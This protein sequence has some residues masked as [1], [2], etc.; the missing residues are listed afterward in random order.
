MRTFTLLL[1]LLAAPAALAQSPGTVEGR[2]DT[3]RMGTTLTVTVQLRATPGN[4]GLGTSTIQFTYND[5]ALDYVSGAYNNY[6]GN[7]ASYDGGFAGYNSTITR[8][9][10]NEVSINIM[11]GFSSFGNGQALPSTYTD[12][13]TF[14]FTITDASATQDLAW[15]TLELRNGPQTRY[16]NGT[17][18]TSDDALPVELT[19]F[20]A[21]QSADGTARL[22]WTTASE[23]DNSGFAIEH[24]AY[25]SAEWANVGWAAGAGTTLEGQSYAFAVSG[26]DP[27]THRFRLIQTDLDGATEQ[28]GVVELAVEMTTGAYRFTSPR[29]NPSAGM[30]RM[31]VAVRQAQRVDVV[32]YDLL[33]R[34][35]AV[36]FSGELDA[37]RQQT[38]AFDAARLSAGM[39]V[40]RLEG[41][42]FAATQVL[43]VAR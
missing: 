28:S 18:E 43:T 12:V 20:A 5:A 36:L 26:L 31:G 13:A 9:N 39:Y 32:A 14:T 4:Q 15:G 2:F 41:E 33:G 29:P 7:Q 3:Q 42:S 17:F 40:L 10:P 11:F 30:T 35:A 22:T 34:R 23:T 38:L 27:G 1:L 16:A 21:T 37:S 25:G 24:G 8:P 6:A 19:G